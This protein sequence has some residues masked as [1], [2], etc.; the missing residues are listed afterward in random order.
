MINQTNTNK[1]LTK[2]QQRI[3]LK[4]KLIY[5][6][7]ITSEFVFLI[8]KVTKE[9]KTLPTQEAKELASNENSNLIQIGSKSNQEPIC[10]IMSLDV[11]LYQLEKKVKS[12]AKNTAIEK[13]IINIG[14]FIETFDLER[15]IKQIQKFL[16]NKNV[17][18]IMIDKVRLKR[19][20]LDIPGLINKINSYGLECTLL[21]DRIY[22][23]TYDKKVI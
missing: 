8:N 16:D 2:K 5:D 18:K 13:H 15:K 3:N 4:H 10:Q 9:Y 1:S 23:V 14:P 19:R 6:D 12:I 20:I 21:S 17:V 22:L 7:K 11:Y